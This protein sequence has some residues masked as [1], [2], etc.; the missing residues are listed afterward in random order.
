MH[1]FS[2]PF[3]A[4]NAAHDVHARLTVL[5]EKAEQVAA[6]VE[7]D[8]AWQFQKARRITRDALRED[9]VADEIDEAVAE[10][11]AAVADIPVG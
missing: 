11:L 8:D 3:P 4:F 2:L 6:D 7:L 10:L 1:V 5:A 9:G